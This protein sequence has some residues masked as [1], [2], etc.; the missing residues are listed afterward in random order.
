[1]KMSEGVSKLT[2]KINISGWIFFFFFSKICFSERESLSVTKMSDL[3]IAFDFIVTPSD[4]KNIKLTNGVIYS[5]C[6]TEI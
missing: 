6:Q 3:F 5:S 1:M 2:R 4:L